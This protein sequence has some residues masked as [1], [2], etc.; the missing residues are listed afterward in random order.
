MAL[1][2]RLRRV[3][4]GIEWLETEGVFRLGAPRR[5]RWLKM[6]EQVEA[7]LARAPSDEGA[8]RLAPYLGDQAAAAAAA[9]GEAAAA[10][11]DPA[12]RTTSS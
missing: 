4:A 12:T 11:S 1:M 5:S 7:R 9:G 3:E 6:K 8:R 2:E 10:I